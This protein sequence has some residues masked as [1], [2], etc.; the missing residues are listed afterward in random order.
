MAESSSR[1]D[2]PGEAAL[3]TGTRAGAVAIE[4]P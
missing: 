4:V 3:R 1:V 2:T